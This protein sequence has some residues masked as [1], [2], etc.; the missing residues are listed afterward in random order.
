MS[1]YKYANSMKLDRDKVS[2]I[3]LDRRSYA[4]IADAHGI[5][6]EQVYDIK[7][8]NIYRGYTDCLGPPPKIS[9]YSKRKEKLTD[10]EVRSIFLDSR[11]R[12]VIA[13]LFQISE[14]T[15][16]N[17]KNGTKGSKYTKVL[18]VRI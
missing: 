8:R 13:R 5:A 7:Y 6:T 12:H 10:K 14:N 18:K 3:F 2:F 16:R 4:E 9:F 17:I 15:V 1:F 11:A